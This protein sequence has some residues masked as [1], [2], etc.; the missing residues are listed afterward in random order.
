[1]ADFVGAGWGPYIAIVTVV[2]IIFCLWLA[3]VMA[4][5]KAAGQGGV[6][7]TGHRWDEDLQELNNPLPRW[8][9]GLFIITIVFGLSYLWLYPGL[10]AVAGSL[11]WS[12]VEQYESEVKQFNA[13]TEPLYA[14]FIGQPI[15]QVSGDAQA[16][17]IG[18]RLYLTYCVQCHGADARGAK[19]YPNL[20][21]GDWLWGGEPLTIKT[22]ILE[23]R[24]AAMPPM[25]QAVGSASDVEN[26][27]HFVVSLSGGGHDSARA[28][29]GKEKFEVCA[30]CHGAAGKGNPALGAPNLTDRIW[31]YGG[32]VSSVIESINKGR[33]GVMPAFKDSLGEGKVHLLT[34]YVW[35]LSRKATPDQAKP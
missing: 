7:T 33:A 12:Q 13:I 19:G 5:G 8:W 20:T 21:D 32:G 35:G 30:A 23:G 9:L 14:K 15:E 31:L 17:G 1:M 10:G 11:G 26:L 29:L 22:T 3:L 28:A 16:R 25:A 2:S 6:G 24:Q 34:A 4:R 27:A 18:E